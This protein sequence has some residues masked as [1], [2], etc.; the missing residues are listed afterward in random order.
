MQSTRAALAPGCEVAGGGTALEDDCDSDG[1][2]LDGHSDPSVLWPRR[3]RLVGPVGYTFQHSPLC[4]PDLG[5]SLHLV[6]DVVLPDS[7]VA[8][9]QFKVFDPGGCVC[10]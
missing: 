9:D 5:S 7:R 8:E 2:E 4:I 1:F 10:V 6:T 3:A